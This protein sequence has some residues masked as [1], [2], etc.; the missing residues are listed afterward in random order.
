MVKPPSKPP[1]FGKPTEQ[2]T[3]QISL[4]ERDKNG[5]LKHAGS[6]TITAWNQPGATISLEDI[7]ARV[8][9]ALGKEK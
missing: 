7:Y 5:R 1:L 3:I 8:E 4:K 6:K 9:E 2:L